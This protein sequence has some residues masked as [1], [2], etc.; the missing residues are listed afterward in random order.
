MGMSMSAELEEIVQCSYERVIIMDFIN[1]Q[2]S[3][4]PDLAASY[5]ALGELHEKK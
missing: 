2:V 4:Y 3:Q 1:S 5:T